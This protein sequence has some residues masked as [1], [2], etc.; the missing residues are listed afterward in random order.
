[1]FKRPSSRRKSEQPQIQLNLVPIL[2]SMVTL[3]SFLMFTMS[4]LS[5]VSVETPFPQA[6]PETNERKLKEKPLQLTVSVREKE[7]EIWSPFNRIPPVVIRH[8]EEGKP[9]AAQLHGKLIEVKQRFPAEAQ[10]VF[11]PTSAMNYDTMVSLMDAMRVLEPTDP[12]IFA[13]N[14]QTGTDEALKQLFPQIVFGN[15][16][17]LGREDT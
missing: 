12:P 9:D 3:I 4:F 17:G 14:P 5:L 8:I 1:M 11:V 16:L 2:D 7:M 6:S 15:L 10:I 13:P